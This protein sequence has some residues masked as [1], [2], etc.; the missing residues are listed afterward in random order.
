[1][2]TKRLREDRENLLLTARHVRPHPARPK[3]PIPA[4]FVASFIDKEVS[5]AALAMSEAA[6]RIEALEAALREL[7]DMTDE[8]GGT[9]FYRV[10]DKA[11]AALGE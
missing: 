2:N 5:I 8:H 11:R 7:V 3:E 10:L 9:G 1:M 6:D 4:K